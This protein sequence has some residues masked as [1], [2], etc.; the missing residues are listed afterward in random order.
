MIQIAKLLQIR[1]C[2]LI[3]LVLLFEKR[4][5]A[6]KQL[7]VGLLLSWKGTWPAAQG[8]ATAVLLAFDDLAKAPNLLPGYNI[9]WVWMDSYCEANKAVSATLMLKD[10]FDIHGYIGA[11]CSVSCT[12]T[13]QIANFYEMPMISW[14]AASPLLSDKQNFPVISRTV[15]PYTKMNPICMAIMDFFGW[16]SAAILGAN[17]D[18][19]SSLGELLLSD[20]EASGYNVLF[21]QSFS[22]VSGELGSGSKLSWMSKMRTTG[23]RIIFALCY[24]NDMRDI[25]LAAK[26][27]DMLEGYM[28]LFFDVIEDCHLDTVGLNDGR[29]EE[30]KALFDSVLSIT[31]YTES[32]DRYEQF[33]TDMDDRRMDFAQYSH[34]PNGPLK[35]VVDSPWLRA[36]Q[37]DTEYEM[38]TIEETATMGAYA[39]FLYDAI[40]MYFLA[41]NETLADGH[42][43]RTNGMKVVEKIKGF[44]FTGVSGDI[45]IDQN[46]DRS[47]NILLNN[48]RIDGDNWFF[49]D[50]A[51]Y[52]AADGVL[53]L[54]VDLEEFRWPGGATE[55]PVDVV[56]TL[57]YCHDED[58]YYAVSGCDVSKVERYV[59]FYWNE[60]VQCEGGVSLPD[61]LALECD[62]VPIGSGV[63]NGVVAITTIGAI[64]GF[65]LLVFVIVLHKKPVIKASQPEFLAIFIVSAMLVSL[66]NNLALGEATNG[67]CFARSWM[68]HLAFTSM[69]GSL[70][71][72]VYRVWRIFGNKN[73]KKVKVTLMDVLKGLAALILVDLFIL[74]LYSIIDAPFATHGEIEI[75]NVGMVSW[76]ECNRSPTFSSLLGMY[77]VGMVVIGVY[78]SVQTRNVS[79]KFSESKYIMFA[80]YQI[81][82]LG[83]LTLLVTSFDT[84]LGLE[85]MIS[86]FGWTFSCIGAIC[87]VLFP[88]LLRIAKPD[89]FPDDGRTAGTGGANTGTKTMTVIGG[90]RQIQVK[91]TY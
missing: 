67:K 21:Y 28:Y 44:Q 56:V 16:Q 72:K 62:Q 40:Y 36:W 29:D 23:V 87:C 57:P 15:G 5:S 11:P 41:A 20:M 55:I 8:C 82:L 2:Y 34:P 27:L 78:I 14:A 54:L 45:V 74:M 19:Y 43:P 79:T 73:L 83:G 85:I 6:D 86:A 25:L 35:P 88:K 80:I 38:P 12:R 84:G 32:T 91:S 65:G 46:G 9:S 76:S 69:F 26:D 68:F 7:N 39:S 24:C 3:F 77:H 75:P 37:N 18:L 48:M 63:A 89:W 53:E 13:G 61:T 22:A 90:A 81:A 71:L 1:T 64:I 17:D 50:V 42:D 60:S 30:A 4:S 59:N 58:Y 51:V 52:V 66:S 70:F 49:E 33:L 10:S 31:W 47:P